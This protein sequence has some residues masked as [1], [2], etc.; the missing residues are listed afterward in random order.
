M[1]NNFFKKIFDSF[2]SRTVLALFGLVGTAVT[3]YAFIQK[4]KVDLRY[5]V[6]A[7]TN[8]LD[9]NAD[10]NKLEV[11]YDSTSL[12]Q[13]QQNLRI[14]TIKVINNGDQNIIKEY[15]DEND[16]LGIQISPGK[17]IERPQVIQTSNDYLKRNVKIIDYQKDK[18]SFSKVILES[19]EFYVV[20]LLVLH[21]KDIPP[22]II[23][24]GK[25]AG[26]KNIPIVNSIDT[27]EQLSFFGKVFFGDVWVQLLRLL[28][29][30]LVGVL[31]ITI[32]IL[33]SERIDSYQRKKGRMKIVE[34][35]KNL[36]TYQ[37]TK[38]DDAIFDRYKKDE[39]NS[40]VNMKRLIEDEG[41]LN[42]IHKKLTEK[43]KDKGYRNLA[44]DINSRLIS[45]RE[46]NDFTVINEMI[47][48][49]IV[50]RE[51]D[52]LVIN[53]A[54]KDTLGKFINFLELK[55]EKIRQRYR[56]ITD[57]DIENDMDTA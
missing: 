5:E 52:H 57:F 51:Q 21:K 29:Y 35:F 15:Y 37:Y 39:H 44:T 30:F 41:Q 1:E 56:P 53:Q 27:K 34:E 45:R 36:K 47:S 55:G 8:V 46:S 2:A 22:V 38:M 16:P 23:S 49:G 3:I 19:G 12:K 20:K 33:F 11:F 25:I 26:Q 6:I 7:N 48:D 9:F 14:Y 32:V 28:L 40:F 17:I 18:I 50:F 31:I 54:M 10:V 24:F 4:E 13:S 42:K 43:L